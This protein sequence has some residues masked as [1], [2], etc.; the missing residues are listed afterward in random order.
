V[1][2]LDILASLTDMRLALVVAH[3]D[4]G[5]RGK[6]SDGDAAFVEELAARYGVPFEVRRVDV[7]AYRRQQKLSLEEAGRI[8]RYEWFD[9]VA[10]KVCARSV[11]LGHHADDQA[12]TF[13]LRLFRGSG[14]TGLAS[15]R[16]LSSAR[17]VRPLLTLT[18]EEILAYL[19]RH[20]LSCRNDSSN[21]DTA[22][23]RN[24]IRHEC[25]PYLKT[26]NPAITERL[27]ATAEILAADEAILEALTGQL[28]PRLSH[29]VSGGIVLDLKAL[30]AELPG[31]RFRLYRR[32]VSVL[33]GDLA[34][35]TT[36]HLKQ[37]DQLVHSSRSQAEQSLPGGVTVL[38]CYEE[39]YFLLPRK[40]CCSE[41]W[42]MSIEGPGRYTLPDGR[43]V[44]VRL[45]AL[46]ESFAD[47]P[48][49][50]AFFDLRKAPF[51]W[52]VR[53]FRPGD[54][55][56]P[57]GMSG[58]C[59]KVK[60]FFI[61]RKIPLPVR[62]MIPLLFSGDELIWVCGFRVAES[63]RILPDARE[64]VEVEFPENSPYSACKTAD[65]MVFHQ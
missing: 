7:A 41:S 32:A 11:A 60:D 43:L 44:F 25:L 53:T 55:F 27:N 49:F 42:E 4:H 28:F 40:G 19:E 26:F 63:G 12:E 54:R 50:R 37:V 33:Q 16:P 57:F 61:D 52:T 18:R 31:M 64:I 14:T 35:I 6:E 48:P 59:K 20:G 5:L 13:L 3:L 23:L 24:R 17:Y 58:A 45:S 30:Q 9:T 56:R 34:R 1:A 8:V 21:D 29:A 36:A 2:L 62:R 38:R 15:M 51:P 39:L 47:L 46:P 22:F 10:R 65:R